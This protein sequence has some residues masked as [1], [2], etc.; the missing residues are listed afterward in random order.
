MKPQRYNSGGTI[1]EGEA[2]ESP[3]EISSQLMKADS[4]QELAQLE[5]PLSERGAERLHL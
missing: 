2:L 3:S 4:I 1:T 5:E